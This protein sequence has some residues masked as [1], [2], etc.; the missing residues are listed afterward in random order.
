MFYNTPQMDGD[1]H[2][3]THAH[4]HARTQAYTYKH[5]HTCMHTHTC[6]HTH[7]YT[8]KA[9]KSKAYGSHAK[10]SY[11]RPVNQHWDAYAPLRHLSLVQAN[12]LGAGLVTH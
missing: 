2:T 11:C 10:H 5:T 3:R 8:H 12:P 1:T 6:T 4:T 9:S 7:A